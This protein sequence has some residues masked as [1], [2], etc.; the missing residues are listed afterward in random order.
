MCIFLVVAVSLACLTLCINCVEPLGV[1]GQ[2]TSINWPEECP[3]WFFWN[4]ATSQCQ[5]PRSGLA[6]AHCSQATNRTWLRWM[7]CMTYDNKS[8]STVVAICPFS[9]LKPKPHHYIL[10]PKNRSQLNGAMCDKANRDGL[11]CSGCK[12]GYGPAVLSYGNSCAKCSDGY[13]GWLLYICLALIPTT[14]FFLVIVLCQVRTTSAPMNLFVLTSQVVSVTA[15]INP[16]Q[17]VYDSETAK[18]GYGIVGTLFTSWNLDFFRFLIPPFCVSE[19][20]SNLQV[21]CMDYIVA[22]YPLLLTVVM[23]ICI[24]Q[25]ARGCRL[26]VC[27]WMPFGYCLSPVVRR[28]NWNPAASTV[29]IFA[30]FLMLSSSKILFVST[31]VLQRVQLTALF[32][33]GQVARYTNRLYYDPNL[34][35]FGQSH[36]PYAV[37]A[38]LVSTTFVILPGLLLI[39]YPTL[40]FQKFLNCCGLSRPAVHA[41]ADAFSGCYKNGT[42]GTRDCR[43]FA[44]FYLLARILI[45]MLSLYIVVL[46]YH[47]LRALLT[48]L[49]LFIFA[50]TSP[51]RNRWFNILDSFWIMLIACRLCITDYRDVLNVICTVYP[52]LYFVTL[53][54]CKI[55][56]SLNCCCCQKLK[57]LADWVFGASDVRPIER[58]VGDVEGNLEGRQANPDGYRHLSEMEEPCRLFF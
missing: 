32:N 41:F 27:L 14:I 20:L 6:H 2:S 44:G 52:I 22:F 48:V 19:S 11:L 5:C 30:S 37:L 9:S 31:N 21:L 46:P 4:K 18:I 15:T 10:L 25:H 23:Y 3:T 1:N 50:F 24:Q 35:F 38:V 40:L 45:I 7:D 51:Y 28:F 29:P 53:V 58:E 54:C 16:H 36:L 56:F 17:L 43:S 8:Y 42:N 12:P 47:S 26:L 57:A 39:L 55:V 13:S 49:V 33:D 34:T